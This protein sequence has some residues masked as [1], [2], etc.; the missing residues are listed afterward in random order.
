MSIRRNDLDELK[1]LATNSYDE[2]QR[3][4]NRV[5]DGIYAMERELRALKTELATLKKVDEED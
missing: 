1:R 3:F 4:L 5:L 2:D